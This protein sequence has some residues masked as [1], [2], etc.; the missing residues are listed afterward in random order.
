MMMHSPAKSCFSLFRITIFQA[1]SEENT[2][3]LL[4]NLRKVSTFRVFFNQLSLKVVAT[5]G[6]SASL[7]G[8]TTGSDLF[9][10]RTVCN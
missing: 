7:W 3:Q 6:F 1:F 4:E 2:M 5:E 10:D 8:D 9:P